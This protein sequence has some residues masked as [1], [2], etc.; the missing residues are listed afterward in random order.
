[1]LKVLKIPSLTTGAEELQLVFISF[2][3]LKAFCS[4][5]LLG[6]GF[7]VWVFLGLFFGLVCF[8][9]PVMVKNNSENY[10]R[11]G[12]FTSFF[13]SVFWLWSCS[14]AWKGVMHPCL[15]GEHSHSRALI[16]P[17]VEDNA[18]MGITGGGMVLWCPASPEG[19]SNPI[20]TFTTK[21]WEGC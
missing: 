12:P 7:F 4:F 17:M 5:V 11:K 10:S 21:P 18:V 6:F 14:G 16:T 2:G 15:E 1:M 13:L 3:L 20:C 8:F 9:F 19:I